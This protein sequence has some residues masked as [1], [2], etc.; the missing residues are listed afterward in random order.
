[1]ASETPSSIPEAGS[2]LCSV[3]SQEARLHLTHMLGSG[4]RKLAME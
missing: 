3:Q 2:I 4:C 1:M